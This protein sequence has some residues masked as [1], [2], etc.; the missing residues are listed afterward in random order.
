MVLTSSEEA[1]RCV[2]TVTFTTIKTIDQL[3]KNQRIPEKDILLVSQ[4]NKTI[5]LFV[6]IPFFLLSFHCGIQLKM[7]LHMCV[8]LCVESHEFLSKYMHICILLSS[9]Q[10][11]DLKTKGSFDHSLFL[12]HT[13]KWPH[14]T[15]PIVFHKT[16]SLIFCSRCV[17]FMGSVVL[18]MLCSHFILMVW[19]CCAVFSL[20]ELVF[21]QKFLSF[22]CT[23]YCKQQ[24]LLCIS[25]WYCCSA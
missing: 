24:T 25:H 4:N 14:F 15:R 2:Y 13:T 6:F 20:F 1:T 23:H 5:I 9:F 12:F 3:P 21:S 18:Y 17:Q 11:L 8:C 7:C 22:H 16:Y 19:E 10:F